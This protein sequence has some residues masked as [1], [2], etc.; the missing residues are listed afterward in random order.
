MASPAIAAMLSLSPP[1]G[2]SQPLPGR[3]VSERERR[4]P[5]R[6]AAARASGARRQPGQ[7]VGRQPEDGDDA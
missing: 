1:A 2:D 6:A 4:R 7:L 5:G 3:G